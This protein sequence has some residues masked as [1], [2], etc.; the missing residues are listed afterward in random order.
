MKWAGH[1]AAWHAWRGAI[2]GERMHHGWIFAGRKGLGKASFAQAA[3]R[4]LVAEAGVPQPAGEHP[5]II[6]LTNLPANADEEKKQ[7]DGK[8]FET[9]RSISVA[10]I[11]AMQQRLTTRPTLGSRRAIIIDPADDLEKPAAN[12]LL[13]SLEEPPVGT[14]FLLV[15]HRPG[16]LLAT[17]RSRCRLLRFPELSEQ[18]LAGILRQ[19]A[20][21][22][23]E[24]AIVAAI[25][26][27]A[28]S[29]GAALDF[30]ELDLAP[31]HG[32]MARI[33][34]QGDPGFHLRGELAEAMG[35]R[36]D[37][38]RQ[39]AALELARAVLA[40]RLHHTSGKELP[41]LI[42]AHAELVRLSGQAP[43]YNFDP[44]LLVLEIGGLLASAAMDRERANG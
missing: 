26:A 16:R 37:R 44:G 43:T 25:A 32:L 40:E 7:A 42:N 23:S 20:P 8:P 17:I 38:K 30:I 34:Q 9:K 39:L 15:A 6:T 2:S 12:A 10:Q 22:A 31:L 3:A 29:A 35:Q 41:P 11:R 36:P 14:Y 19:Q 1:D 4:E 5:D 24:A 13:K 28:G 27:G 18:E 21:D 33:A